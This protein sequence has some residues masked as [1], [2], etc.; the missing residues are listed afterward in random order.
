[1]PRETKIAVNT[2]V[3]IP[4][5]KVNANPLI[6]PNIAE[7]GPRFP[8]MSRP[9]DKELNEKAISKPL[10]KHIYTA[11]PSAHYFEGKIYDV[12]IEEHKHK[13][14]ANLNVFPNPGNGS[15]TISTPN[16]GQAELNVFD[17]SGKMVLSQKVSSEETKVDLQNQ[18]D[19]MYLFIL[20]DT[21]NL[22]TAKVVKY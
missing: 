22:R 1:M 21:D 11:D 10:V 8:D 12:G 7:M 15:F 14:V 19:G 9:Y 13:G 6:G 20:H 2:E 3:K 16:T 18:P 4:N 17:L 5:V